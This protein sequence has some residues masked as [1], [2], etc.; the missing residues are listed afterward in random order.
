MGIPVTTVLILKQALHIIIL[1]GAKIIITLKHQN[2]FDCLG[3]RIINS[4]LAHRSF[5]ITKRLMT[6]LDLATVMDIRYKRY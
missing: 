2:R 1:I 4:A 3:I 5:F 6:W